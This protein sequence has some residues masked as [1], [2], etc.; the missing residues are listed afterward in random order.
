MT[1]AAAGHGLAHRAGP[2][3]AVRPAAPEIDAPGGFPHTETTM[4]RALLLAFAVAAPLLAPRPARAWDDVGHMVVARIAWESMTPQARANAVAI[5][6]G[7]PA[8]TGISG[9]AD[10]PYWAGDD[11]GRGLF[12]RTST[13]ADIIRW[14]EA[15]GHGFH[16]PSWHYVNYFWEQPVPGGP[17]HELVRPPLGAAVDTLQAFINELS[18]GVVAPERKAVVLAWILHLAGDVHQP[19]HASARVTPT[20]PDGDKGGNDFKLDGRHNLHSFWDGAITRGDAQWRPGDRNASDLIG[21]IATRI[22]HAFPRAR[23]AS[24]LLPAQV[25][26][27]AHG[28]YVTATTLYPATLHRGEPAP[29]AYDARSKP[30]AERAVAL[31]GYRLADVL[32]RALAQS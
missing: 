24:T 6:R 27:W 12:V 8:A 10:D 1:H 30:I 2:C 32:N 15:V 11:P 22:M 13:W 3:Q 5:L 28:S 31:G 7:A 25:E 4:K 29:A 9:L 23:L 21:G 20:E 18:S 17:P 16:Q 26:R 14:R 19:L